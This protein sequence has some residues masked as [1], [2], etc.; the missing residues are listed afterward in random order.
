MIQLSEVAS[1]E[2]ATID[3]LCRSEAALKQAAHVLS[4]TLSL[5]IAVRLETHLR[6]QIA[7]RINNHSANRSNRDSL[8][9]QRSAQSCGVNYYELAEKPHHRQNSACKP[10]GY[11]KY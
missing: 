5:E 1:R 7:K 9:I 11:G 8:H 2:A 10:E 6:R 3:G 4:G